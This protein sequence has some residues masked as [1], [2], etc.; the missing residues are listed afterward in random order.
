MSHRAVPPGGSACRSVL[1][2]RVRMEGT[3]RRTRKRRRQRCGSQMFRLRCLGIITSKPSLHR[4]LQRTY[5][6]TVS[7]AHI[8]PNRI[9]RSQ[10]D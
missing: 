7:P 3:S 1:F 5:A 8:A 6:R 10:L 9:G 4:T 2:V